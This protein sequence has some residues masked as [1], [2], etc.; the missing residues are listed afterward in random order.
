M[1]ARN[2]KFE[3]IKILRNTYMHISITDFCVGLC[4]SI[5]EILPS[6]TSTIGSKGKICGWFVGELFG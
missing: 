4:Y 2:G 3:K 1:R 6:K 5:N